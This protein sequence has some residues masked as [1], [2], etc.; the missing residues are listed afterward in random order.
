MEQVVWL[1]L[2][3]LIIASTF[4]WLGNMSG[5]RRAASRYF[6]K[7]YKRQK[8][9]DNVVSNRDQAIADL[10]M[11]YE[12]LTEVRLELIRRQNPTLDYLFQSNLKAIEGELS[13]RLKRIQDETDRLVLLLG[14]MDVDLLNIYET[15]LQDDRITASSAMSDL[16]RLGEKIERAPDMIQ[17]NAT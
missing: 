12:R 13:A 15:R 14:K 5:E 1:V 10:E 2:T 6:R 11:A 16:S 9:L 3:A 7:E 17:Q 4:Y 8:L